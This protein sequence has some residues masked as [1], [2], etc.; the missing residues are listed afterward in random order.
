MAIAQSPVYQE[1][2]YFL[3]SAPSHEAILAFRPSDATRERI[4]MLLAANKENRLCADEQAELDEF[5]QVEH[6]VRML[7]LHTQQ[8]NNHALT[9]TQ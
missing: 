1:V 4:R 5:E 3:A 2:Y 9:S 6:L 7:K 8:L